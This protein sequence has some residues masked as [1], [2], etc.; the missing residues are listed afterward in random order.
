VSAGE[1][2]PKEE[3]K[4]GPTPAELSRMF[5]LFDQIVVS[6]PSEV[7]PLLIESGGTF[8]FGAFSKPEV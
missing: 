4:N 7:R 6:K 2:A 3:N 8:N 1:S 5:K